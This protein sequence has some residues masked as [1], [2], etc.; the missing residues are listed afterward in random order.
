MIINHQITTTPA[1]LMS[2]IIT[3]EWERQRERD[4]ED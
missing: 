3:I 1:A 4:K 2:L